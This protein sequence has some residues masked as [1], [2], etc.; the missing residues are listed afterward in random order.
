MYYNAEHASKSTGTEFKSDPACCCC[1]EY[2]TRRGVRNVILLE[3]IYL[4]RFTIFI[5][6]VILI[7][8]G[9]HA[10]LFLNRATSHCT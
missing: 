9:I 10:Q 6:I 2:F 1:R 5:F 4:E 3:P 8:L 7:I